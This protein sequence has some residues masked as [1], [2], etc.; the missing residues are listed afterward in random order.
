MPWPIGFETLRTRL[1]KR[2]VA[3][4]ALERRLKGPRI[5]WVEDQ[6]YRAEAFEMTFETS[7][8]GRPLSMVDCLIR[9]MLEDPNLRINYLATWNARDFEDVCQAR[10]IVILEG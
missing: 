5:Q 2:R 3:M 4:Q 10:G 9:L 7:R 8:K 1:V 6:P